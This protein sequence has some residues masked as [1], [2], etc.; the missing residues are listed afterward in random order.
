MIHLIGAG[1]HASVIADIV[2][3]RAVDGVVLWADQPP[4]D[5]RFSPDVQ[6][7]PLAELRPDTPVILA[8]GDL[9]L[10][11]ELRARY[12]RAADALTDPSSIVG[13]G[14]R[15]EPGTVVKPGVIINA[16]AVVEQDAILNTGC[17]IEHDCRIARNT[18]VAPG[19]RLGG[20]VIVGESTLIGTGAIVLPE[21]SVGARAS[22]GAGAVVVRDVA[23]GETV[24]GVPAR[25]RGS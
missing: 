23:D 25:R 4:R 5:G 3:R 6:W 10:R 14:V 20:G 8:I 22:V 24:I 21:V 13:H 11:V 2:R 16:N 17:I 18:H 19:A 9:P 1:G 12:P 15:L 7:R